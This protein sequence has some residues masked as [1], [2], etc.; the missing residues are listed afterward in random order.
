[1]GEN[2]LMQFWKETGGTLDFAKWLFVAYHEEDLELGGVG[3]GVPKELMDV[4]LT[5]MKKECD[6]YTW[7]LPQKMIKLFSLIDA[8]DNR[9]VG[10][11]KDSMF[12]KIANERGVHS[13]SIK[14]SYNQRKKKLRNNK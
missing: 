8:V 10:T 13:D 12:E 2:S 9:P 14:K 7:K 5:Q 1:M 3:G 11:T 4:I 6:Y